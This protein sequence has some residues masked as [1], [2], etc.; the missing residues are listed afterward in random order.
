[1][2]VAVDLERT[3]T[4]A[5]MDAAERQARTDLAAAY[6]LAAHFKWTD[7]IY[8]HFTAKIPGTE[9]ILIN[10][11]GLMFD[12]IKASS[13]VKLTLDGE[14]LSDSTGLGINR[15]GYVIHS[16]IH[17]ARPD[18]H[19]IMHTHS[20]AGVAVSAMKCG[21]LPLSQHAMRVQQRVTYHDYEG[22]AL[23][24]DEQVRLA[25]DLGL[26][27]PAMILR[28]H[29][30]LAVGASMHEAFDVMYYLE[31]A[32][33]IQVDAMAGGIDNLIVMPGAAADTADAQFHAETRSKGARAWTSL[34][35]MLDRHGSDFRD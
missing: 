33:Q 5:P 16:C 17:R 25:R 27:A 3:A 22:I 18:A 12:E 20:R 31:C 13:L 24:L 32:C 29:G 35:H 34:L 19:A 15:A 10:P 14:I 2:S 6:R 11:F 4:T 8:T 23:E 28:N 30:L 9:H 1:M 7:L 21:L 26:D